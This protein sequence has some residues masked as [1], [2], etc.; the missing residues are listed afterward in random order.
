MGAR[1]SLMKPLLTLLLLFFFQN[2]FA[3]AGCTDT[4]YRMRFYSPGNDL[5]FYTHCN[6]A[7]GGT[8]LIGKMNDT[9]SSATSNIVLIKLD[10]TGGLVWK[11]SVQNLSGSD[12]YFS[13]IIEQSNGE[14]A[15]YG[16]SRLGTTSRKLL[17]LKL[18]NAGTFLWSKAYTLNNRFNPDDYLQPYFLSEGLN[19]DLLFSAE[20]DYDQMDSAQY[21]GL[22]LR[23]DNT[24]NIVWS[25]AILTQDNTLGI[26]PAGIYEVNG[27]IAMFGYVDNTIGFCSLS[28]SPFAIKMDYATGQPFLT[29]AYCHPYPVSN[30]QEVFNFPEKDYNNS[31]RLF[32]NQFALFGRFGQV[33][34]KRYGYKVVFDDQL[35]LIKARQYTVPYNTLLNLARVSVLPDETTHFYFVG[36]K[37]IYWASLDS[38]E[39]IIRQRKTPIDQVGIGGGGYLNFGYRNRE[40]FNFLTNFRNNNERY[41]LF[42]QIQRNDPGIDSCLGSDTAFAGS[43]PIG[44]SLA[45]WTWKS[46]IDNPLIASSIALTTTDFIV[47]TEPLCT[48]ISRCDSL[49]IAGPDTVCVTNNFISFT[50][51]KNAECRKRVLWEKLADGIYCAKARVQN[52]VMV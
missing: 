37:Q 51:T 29:K 32:N 50:G 12:T 49:R 20:G 42:T 9:A 18:S 17:L 28:L 19:N 45:T 3:Q 46:I 11:T 22:A 25:K 39:K 15:A 5:R 7:D 4:S 43:N 34:D 24:G 30:T 1:V 47:N 23:T 35:N 16:Y 21:Y 8:V 33:T 48:Q 44:Y 40:A 10:A 6:T 38:S 52:G 2:L 41:S 26:A 13:R 31:I 27:S 36:N 14:L